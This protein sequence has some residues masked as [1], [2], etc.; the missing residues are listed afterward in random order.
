M[1]LHLNVIYHVY[2]EDNCSVFVFLKILF[3]LWSWRMSLQGILLSL[4]Q[5]SF[6]TLN[7]LFSCLQAFIIAIEKLC[8]VLTDS[9]VNSFVTSSSWTSF[10]SSFRLFYLGIFF[11]LFILF[12]IC[13]PS[14][15]CGLI[16][17]LPLFL[18]ILSHYLFL[19][20]FYLF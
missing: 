11:F 5:F 1:F 15:I 12:R 18:E 16:S 9:A 20:I 14:W 4:Q 13:W 19:L 2:A 10:F 6:C 17:F 7:T 8:Y 3:Y